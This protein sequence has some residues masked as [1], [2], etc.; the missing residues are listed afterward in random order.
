MSST[1]RPERCAPLAWRPVVRLA[2]TL[3]VP[4]CAIGPPD[5]DAGSEIAL[6][7]DFADAVEFRTQAGPIDVT[8]ADGD[9]LTLED[10]VRRAIG[11]S[12]ELQAA[13]ARVRVAQADA[14]LTGLLPNPILS[15]SL[16]VPAGHGGTE[17]EAGLAAD[18]LALLQRPRR[19]A[20]AGHRLEAE[21]AG[22]VSTAL[23]VIA[24]VQV[25]Y[26]EVQVLEELVPVLDQRVAVLDRLLHVAQTRLQ[27]GAASRHE[28]T[29]IESE[30]T[31]LSVEVARQRQ[32]LRVA[33]LLLARRVGE[34]SSPATWRLDPWIAP[35]PVPA[36]DEAAWLAAALANRPEVA[37]IA[38]EILARGVDEGLAEGLAFDG[39]TVGLDAEQANGWSAG[40]ATGLPLPLFDSGGRRRERA[41]ALTAEMRHRLTEAQRSVIEDVRSALAVFTG[42]QANLRRIV[43]E[44]IP[45]QERRRAEIEQVYRAGQSDVTAL[46]FAD[47]ALQRAHAI[48]IELERDASASLYR[49]QRAVGGPRAFRSLATPAP[50]GD[51]P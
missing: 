37:A 34:P 10:A 26:A 18:L 1:V 14:E 6:S 23:D 27:L 2:L 46:L 12:A 35:E 47:E 50:D 15:V 13:L 19:A 45:L 41:Q 36:A 39:A 8:P 28:V 25:R 40:P 24:D 51:V 30:R 20:A 49:L 7:L 3:L 9:R 5:V 43:S 42:A 31:E 29:S 21:A 4:A 48:R 11:T 17:V 44:L 33:R 16:R 22:C 32:N 38:W